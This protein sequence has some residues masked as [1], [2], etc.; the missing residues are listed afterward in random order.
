MWRD[1]EYGVERGAGHGD[2]GAEE[3]SGRGRNVQHVLVP[4]RECG[5]V[6]VLCVHVEAAGRVEL[7]GTDCGADG[8]GGDAVRRCAVVS[9]ESEVV[10]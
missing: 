2:G 1:G 9:G 10:A 6:D 3:K 7:E 5:G 4:G 8:L